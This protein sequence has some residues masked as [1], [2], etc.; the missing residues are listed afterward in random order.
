MIPSADL[1]PANLVFAL[2]LAVAV[3]LPF[4][5]TK[6]LFFVGPLGI[7]TVELPLY[8]LLAVSLVRREAWRPSSW[9]S[10]HWAAILWA[11]A[12]L[13]SAAAAEG[14]RALALRF[15]LRM[16]V[17]AALVFPV[18]AATRAPDRALRVL[19][20][21]VTGAVLS[22]AMA[23][24][25]S[26]V[27]GAPAL[28]V[29][30]KTATVRV[31]DVVR[32]SGPFPYPN[33]AAL[34]WAAALPALLVIDERRNGGKTHRLRWLRITGCAFIVA[35]IVASGSRGA[36]LTTAIVLGMLAFMA[37]LSLRP[38]ARWALGLLAAA[39]VTAVLLRPPLLLRDTSQ[40]GEASWFAGQ[41]ERLGPPTTMVAGQSA[42]LQVRA[43]NV[44]AL[45]WEAT[46]PRPIAVGA[47]WRDAKGRIAH[48][49]PAT[50]LPT[51]VAPGSAAVLRMGL[52]APEHPG[53]YGLHVQLVGEGTS[54]ET[55]A[56]AADLPIEVT[57]AAA[58]P[59]AWPS[60]RPAQRQVTRAELWRAGWR[61]FRERPLL[62]VGPDGFR[63]LY[64]P[65][66]GPRALDDRVNA[67]SLYVETLADLGL[68][69]ALALAVVFAS[70]ARLATFSAEPDP[71]R[72]LAL[73]SAAA[74]LAFALHGLVDSPLAVTPLHALFWI[75]AGLLAR[76]AL[77]DR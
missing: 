49:E 10:V 41:F 14:N 69:G 50:V 27:P 40:G 39:A 64:G 4:E 62:G 44:G 15:A 19:Q 5:A 21:L 20:S 7:T 45:A 60:P 6:P 34:Y 70:L 8:A 35:A 2:L 56:S 29:A 67:N 33:P 37:P 22:A 43:R 74:L 30:F 73:G 75:H 46:G 57:G 38:R 25:E 68:A 54:F 36:V 3:L 11:A 77:R 76:Q 65:Y 13:A 55:P 31:G 9:T 59:K 16:C 58:P 42:V 18:A 32:A 23:V 17:G 24:A 26:F 28:L 12:H 61:M 48:E 72:G 66:L 53:Q 51:S 47:Q 1:V 63:R 71:E 52:T